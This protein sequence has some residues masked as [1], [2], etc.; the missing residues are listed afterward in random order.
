MVEGDATQ[1]GTEDLVVANATGPTLTIL[2][3]KQDGSF[4]RPIAVGKG[5]AAG[6]LAVSDFDG[7]GSDD[8]AVAGGGQIEVYLGAD[9]TLAGRTT[10]STASSSKVIAT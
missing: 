6:S 1:D 4:D 8:L 7:D 9:A 10:L 2:P 5:P 3:G